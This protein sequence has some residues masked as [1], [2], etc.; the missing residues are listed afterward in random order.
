MAVWSWFGEV[1]LSARAE[2]K[3]PVLVLKQCGMSG[4]LAVVRLDF[5]AE[6][7]RRSDGEG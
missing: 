6:L 3:K 5:L 2:L 4:E 1:N 7:L